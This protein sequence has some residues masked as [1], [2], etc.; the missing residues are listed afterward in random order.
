VVPEGGG[1]WLHL[2]K[3]PAP[4]VH[5]TVY[6]ARVSYLAELSIFHIP[7]RVFT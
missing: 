1:G 4:Q 2:N 6:A 7:L 5:E 3:D